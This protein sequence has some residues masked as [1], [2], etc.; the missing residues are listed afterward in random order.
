MRLLSRVVICVT[1]ATACAIP[2]SGVTITQ[3][4]P[5][6]DS[7]WVDVVWSS[8]VVDG[9]VQVDL[10]KAFNTPEMMGNSMLLQF[11][12]DANDVGKDIW[13]V[14]DGGDGNDVGEEVLNNTGVTWVDYHFYLVNVPIFPSSPFADAAFVT[15]ANLVTSDA[16]GDPDLL[17]AERIDFSGGPV[18]HGNAVHFT[19]IRI[20]HNGAEGD[21][22]S[23]KQI[24]IPEPGTLLLLVGGA[25]ALA[26]VRKRRT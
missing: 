10:Q 24:P 26:V 14:H 1:A 3:I 15:D 8:S 11:T 16:F 13:I 19:G 22:F 25:L 4:M 2:A 20:T 5:A 17:T 12:L 7:N 21:I 23:L 6:V 9:N 18:P